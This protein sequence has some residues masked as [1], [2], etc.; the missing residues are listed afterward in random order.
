[1][2]TPSRWLGFPNPV[3]EKA[4][5]VVA[6]GV[7]TIAVLT[8]LTGWHWLI[9]VMAAGFL[10][11][12]LTG[13]RLSVLGQLATRVIAPRL[14]PPTWV[15]GPPKRF[16]QAA[17]LVISA[18][19]AVLSLA[20]DAPMLGAVLV[21]LILAFALMESVIGFCVACWLFGQLMAAGLVPQATCDACNNVRAR[22]GRNPAEVE[23]LR[24]EIPRASAEDSGQIV[25]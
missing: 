8:L 2:T 9:L 25:A 19:A 23:P 15:P 22:Y 20:F 13:P 14:G 24:H 21:A 4:A 18:L 10:A 12:V 3:N 1:M 5:R 16:A 11:R 6:G 17:G 7:A